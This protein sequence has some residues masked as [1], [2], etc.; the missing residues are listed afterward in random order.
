MLA[1]WVPGVLLPA[2]VLLLL[3]LP[4]GAGIC[5]GTLQPTLSG[6][7][8]GAR[9]LGRGAVAAAT[10]GAEHLAKTAAKSQARQ[11]VF[12]V[13]WSLPAVPGEEVGMGN[14]PSWTRTGLWELGRL[15]SRETVF[16]LFHSL[17]L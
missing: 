6:E 12:S 15:G 5:V 11:A 8:P 16:M 10:R 17:F 2:S 9:R 7:A 3:G 4:E 14:W 1:A 13:P